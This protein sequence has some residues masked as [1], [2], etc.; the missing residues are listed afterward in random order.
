M[1][2][3]LRLLLKSRPKLGRHTQFYQILYKIKKMAPEL[4]KR[5]FN[6]QNVTLHQFWAD[7]PLNRA[8]PALIPPRVKTG[9][10]SLISLSV[11]VRGASRRLPP[12][13]QQAGG[14]ISGR[15]RL[16]GW[17]V[18]FL[19]SF[20]PAPALKRIHNRIRNETAAC[21]CL[22]SPAV[23]IQPVR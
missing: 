23:R 20:T 1:G 21:L 7:A 5:F 11:S 12:H 14:N 17:S 13:P 2:C 22:L 9:K 10:K 15:A 16:L 18:R 6:S 19:H 4:L 8:A 3:N